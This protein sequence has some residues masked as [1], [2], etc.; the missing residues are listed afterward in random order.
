MLQL[1]GDY[2]R[3]TGA[4]KW[5]QEATTSEADQ[6]EVLQQFLSADPGGNEARRQQIS[7]QAKSFVR[8][9]RRSDQAAKLWIGQIKAETG[10]YETAI[11]YFTRWENP[12]WQMAI[13]YSLARVYEA[14]GDSAKAI[15]TYREDESP[16]RHG[17]LLRARRLEK[18]SQAKAEPSADTR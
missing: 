9:I 4:L 17:N 16:Q 1:A 18:L 11:N 3:E 14:Q 10:E 13:N 8:E 5:L 2:S 6:D 7:E 15:Q 12:L